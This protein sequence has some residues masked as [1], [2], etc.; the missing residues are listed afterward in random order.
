MDFLSFLYV[1]HAFTS[2]PP[3]SVKAVDSD[4]R[5]PNKEVATYGKPTKAFETLTIH[6]QSQTVSCYIRIYRFRNNKVLSGN[7]Y[8]IYYLFKLQMGFYPVAV[9]LQ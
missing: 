4:G 3:F 1:F 7:K 2:F 6:T 9:V 5:V 8:F